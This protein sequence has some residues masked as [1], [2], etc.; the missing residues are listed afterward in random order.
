MDASAAYDAIN[1]FVKLAAERRMKPLGDKKKARLELLDEQ[2]RD[3]IEGAR[4]APK[5]ISNPS[6][7]TSRTPAHGVAPAKIQVKASEALNDALELSTQDKSK[8]NAVG[9]GAIPKS[10]YTP[11][12]LP[13]FMADYYSDSLVPAKLTTADVPKQAVSATGDTLDLQHEVRVL[14]G[15]ERPAGGGAQIG[16]AVSAAPSPSAERPA[17]SVERP[18]PGATPAP[19]VAP[20][21][22]PSQQVIVHLIAGGT[23]R[24]RIQ[25]FEPKTGQLQLIGKDPSAPP[26]PLDLRDVLAVFFGPEPGKPATVPSGTR[27]TVKLNN[28]RQISGVSKDY[29]EGGDSLTV[30]PSPRRGNLDHIWIPAWAVKAIE[31]Q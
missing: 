26:T 20:A 1:E 14:L 4:P 22:P 28:E 8:L 7:A 21:G 24:G 13:A 16:P 9:A 25:S 18:A 11:P 3:V 19:S 30:V 31:L 29:S 10:S 23:Q 27:L 12:A 17:P 2:I 15:L 6:A 5:R